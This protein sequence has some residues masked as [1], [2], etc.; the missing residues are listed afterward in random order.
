MVFTCFYFTQ[1]QS[2]VSFG[3]LKGGKPAYILVSALKQSECRFK[4]ANLTGD[5]I[6]LYDFSD[7]KTSSRSMQFAALAVLLIQLSAK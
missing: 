5:T 1:R 3:L 6:A 4:T 2:T 7:G